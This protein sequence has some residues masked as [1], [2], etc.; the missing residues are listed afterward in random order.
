MEWLNIQKNLT[1][2][3]YDTI[4][5]V[6]TH[7]NDNFQDEIINETIICNIGTVQN[8]QSRIHREKN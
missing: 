8:E 6:I 3:K 4:T 2:K 5:R 7:L 1:N